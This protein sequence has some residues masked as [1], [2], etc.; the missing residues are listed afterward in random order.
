MFKVWFEEFLLRVRILFKSR[1]EKQR[2]TAEW[3]ESKMP[4]G[5]N[6][7]EV[8]IPY[9]TWASTSFHSFPRFPSVYRYRSSGIDDSDFNI[10]LSNSSYAKVCGISRH[11]QAVS[12]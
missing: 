1:K 7:F 4:I 6:P 2:I 11:I 8:A 10:H 3:L 9:R 5:T 12:D